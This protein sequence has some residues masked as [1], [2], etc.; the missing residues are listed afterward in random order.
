MSREK[1]IGSVELD[2]SPLAAF[3]PTSAHSAQ[4]P[5][6][7]RPTTANKDI[8]THDCCLVQQLIIAFASGIIKQAPLYIARIRNR[9]DG[10]IK[11]GRPEHLLISR[12]GLFVS[13]GANPL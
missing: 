4:I 2:T 11:S 1:S 7:A 10:R 9:S 8:A 13:L 5:I 6:T 3:R 12:Q